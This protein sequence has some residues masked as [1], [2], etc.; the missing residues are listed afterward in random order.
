[1]SLDPK[2]G[3]APYGVSSYQDRVYVSAKDGVY[4]FDLEGKY[5]E[6]WGSFG[7]GKNQF[8]YANGIATDPN[9]GNVY[10]ADTGNSR[11]VALTP[12]G[13]VRWLLGAP[14]DDPNSS[15]FGLPKGIAVADDGRIFI[16]DTFAHKVRIIDSEGKLLSASG[17]R[18]TVGAQFSFPEGIAITPSY[19]M[20]LVDR[21]NN[22]LQIWQLGEDLPKIDPQTITKFGWALTVMGS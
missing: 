16:S 22:R 8:Q 15:V 14:A 12:E 18:G 9:N 2:L 4:V 5:M 1:M 3:W 21:Q 6:H 20:Y 17:E 7:E 13:K 10:V 19:R 11:I